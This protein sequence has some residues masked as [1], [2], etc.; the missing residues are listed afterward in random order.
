MKNVGLR[1]GLVLLVVAGLAHGEAGTQRKLS[2]QQIQL[3]EHVMG[4]I[5]RIDGKRL[6]VLEDVDPMGCATSGVRLVD[7]VEG[8]RLLRSGAAIVGSDLQ[9]GDRVDIDATAHGDILEAAEIRV[10]ESGSGEHK[11]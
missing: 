10:D 2:T 7:I 1:S 3:K 11:H 8:T 9:R 6:R 5:A 4:T